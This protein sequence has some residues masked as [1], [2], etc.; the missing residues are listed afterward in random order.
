MTSTRAP[1]ADGTR[2][3]TL[4]LASPRHALRLAVVWHSA[5]TTESVRINGVL[6]PARADLRNRRLAPG[7]NRIVVYGSS[8]HVEITQ[9]G[10]APTEAIVSDASIGLPASAAALVR[11]RDAAGAVPV[12]AGDATIVQ[13]RVTW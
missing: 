8:A 10:D 13:R 7:W 12:Q 6:P 11:V 4:D 5:A 1:A 9:R 2:V 3:V